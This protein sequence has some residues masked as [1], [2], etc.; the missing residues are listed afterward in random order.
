MISGSRLTRMRWGVRAVLALG[1]AASISANVLHAHPNP[2]SQT[3]AGWPPIALLLT[4]ELISRIPVNRQGLATARIIATAVIAGIAAWVSYR[5]MAGVAA[6]Y[7]ETG[8]SAYLLPLSVDGL[9]VVASICLVELG[10]QPTTAPRSIPEGGPVTAP[11]E[12]ACPAP[13]PTIHAAPSIGPSDAPSSRCTPAAVVPPEPPPAQLLARDKS[14]GS[15]A[16]RSPALTAG[17]HSAPSTP[18]LDQQYLVYEPTS[19]DDQA[20]YQVWLRGVADGEE[21]SGADLARA[22][23]RTDDVTGVGRRAARRYRHAHA[24]ADSVA[25]PSSARDNGASSTSLSTVAS[26]LPQD[27]A[28]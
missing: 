21:P 1:V 9:I 10:G 22:T 6:R 20:M 12:A 25:S 18:N 7:G 14:A 16:E 15:S 17:S 13:D 19:D 28:V 4:V 11:V 8:A 3:I 23:G 27:V 24:S 26:P 2:I 5:H